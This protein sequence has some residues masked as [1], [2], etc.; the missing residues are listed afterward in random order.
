MC[1]VPLFAGCGLL[2]PGHDDDVSPDAEIDGP[3]PSPANLT[4]SPT[5]LDTLAT[6]VGTTG[7]SFALLVTNDG[8]STS[9]AIDALTSDNVQLAVESVCMS[10]APRGTC[11]VVGRFSPQE[12]VSTAARI[13]IS[14]SPGGTRTVAVS[15]IGLPTLNDVGL[16][17]TPITRSGPAP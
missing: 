13:T 2:T 6:P 9:G 14:A 1:V 12:C 10:L 16:C 17:P 15:G 4:V 8:G 7:K 11:F 3:P 5:S